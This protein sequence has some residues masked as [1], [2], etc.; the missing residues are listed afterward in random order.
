[1]TS[2]DPSIQHINVP[3]PWPRN[4]GNWLCVTSVDMR[5]QPADKCQADVTIVH[6]DLLRDK[7]KQ[8]MDRAI[9]GW[10]VK[11]ET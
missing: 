9:P 8:D 10:R 5:Q 6:A 7:F 4:A 2:A 11:W 1:M 3:D